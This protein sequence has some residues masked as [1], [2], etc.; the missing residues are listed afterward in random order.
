MILDFTARFVDE[1]LDLIDD[2]VSEFRIRM[3]ASH[4]IHSVASTAAKYR[5]LRRTRCQAG[6]AS[7]M[8][9]VLEEA[10]Q[11]TAWLER[12]ERKRLSRRLE[13]IRQAIFVAD[14]IIEKTFP[15]RRTVQRLPAYAFAPGPNRQQRPSH[16]YFPPQAD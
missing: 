1:L 3:L 14:E 13:P 10:D 16:R 4:L 9:L 5:A 8:C 6:F 2:F 12:M 11:S 7:K 15:S